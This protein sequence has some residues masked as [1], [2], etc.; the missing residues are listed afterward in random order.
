MGY[1]LTF[2][3]MVIMIVTGGAQHRDKRYRLGVR[4]EATHGNRQFQALVS[5]GHQDSAPLE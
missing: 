1:F 4:L 3:I 2:F 5:V